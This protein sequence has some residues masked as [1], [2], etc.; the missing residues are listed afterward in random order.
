MSET[1][2]LTSLITKNLR[3]VTVHQPSTWIVSLEGD[4]SIAIRRQEYNITPHGTQIGRLPRVY[5]KCCISFVFKDRKIVAVQM[6]LEHLSQNGQLNNLRGYLRGVRRLAEQDRPVVTTLET[7][8]LNRSL[9]NLSIVKGR[10]NIQSH[11]L[12]SSQ[13]QP[14]NRLAKLLRCC[15]DLE[16]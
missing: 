11:C 4:D 9:R 12:Y 6:D 2:S 15:R 7:K 3:N 16:M 10:V 13:A 1:N 5:R 14:P 8:T